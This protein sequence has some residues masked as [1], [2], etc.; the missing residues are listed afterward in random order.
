MEEFDYIETPENVELQRRLAG[1][2]SRVYAGFIDSLILGILYLLFFIFFV[3]AGIDPIKGAGLS[4][5]IEIWSLAILIFL[6]FAVYWGY[7]I[8]FETITNGQTIGK[9]YTKIRVVQKEGQGVTF[10]SI[11]VRNLLRTVDAVGVYSVGIISMF[12]TEKIQR[13]GDLAAGTVVISENTPEFS[14]SSDDK[15][16]LIVEEAQTVEGVLEVGF[17]AEEYKLLQNYW[18]RRN[19]FDLEARKKILTQ[20]FVPVL[21]RLG[22][23]SPHSSVTSLENL[24]KMLLD[25]VARYSS[26]DKNK[27]QTP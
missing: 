24:L 2:G 15:K 21:E 13:L 16:E 17:S 9:K 8:L 12:A 27:G 3:V 14:A 11:V 4:N 1:I 10:G 25:R 20:L 18:A 7:F 22:Y 6:G 19:E 23:R 26:Q 5:S